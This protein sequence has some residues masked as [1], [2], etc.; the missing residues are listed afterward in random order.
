MSSMGILSTII[1]IIS[2][3][4]GIL[5]MITSAGSSPTYDTAKAT[6]WVWRARATND[7][8][9]MA[10]NLNK[11]YDIIKDMEGN[12]VWLW[13]TPWTDIEQIKLNL[14]E[15]IKNCETY[16]NLT[17]QMAYQQAVHNLQETLVE[18]ADHLGAVSSWQYWTPFNTFVI[19]FWWWFWIIPIFLFILDW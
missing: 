3:I 1:W 10:N 2:L 7:L 16:S 6:D 4:V 11:A 18:I 13:P 8:N 17:D 9:D 14:Q 5:V 19:T 15:C 12:P